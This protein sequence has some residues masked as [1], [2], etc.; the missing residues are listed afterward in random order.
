MQ[1]L[2][3]VLLLTVVVVTFVSI[4]SILAQTSNYVIQIRPSD[5]QTFWGGAISKFLPDGS[6]ITSHFINS[7]GAYD[8]KIAC[9]PGDKIVAFAYVLNSDI[10]QPMITVNALLN[11]KII[12][13][14]TSVGLFLNRNV[15]PATIDIR[16]CP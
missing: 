2:I 13:S 1:L 10:N 14:K 9:L 5:D 7:S 15:Q 11:D 3:G 12:Q 4:Q 6:N 16:S 8:S